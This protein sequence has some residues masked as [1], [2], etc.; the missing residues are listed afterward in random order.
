MGVQVHIT[1]GLWCSRFPELR[2]VRGKERL[3]F[4]PALN[5]TIREAVRDAR[6]YFDAEEDPTEVR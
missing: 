5:K 1:G 2:C 4:V 3:S 6:S